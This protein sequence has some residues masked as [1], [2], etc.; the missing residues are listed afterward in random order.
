MG[1]LKSC[2]DQQ[3]GDRS[4]R[5]SEDHGG[6]SEAIHKKQAGIHSIEHQI[7]PPV[8]LEAELLATT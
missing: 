2:N 6:C 5:E 4:I 7:I 1:D 3:N 8:I